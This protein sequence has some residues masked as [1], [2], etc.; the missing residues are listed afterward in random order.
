MTGHASDNWSYQEKELLRIFYACGTP[1]KEIEKAFEGKSIKAISKKG[2]RMLLRHG[3]G[4]EAN[5]MGEDWGA[6]GPKPVI[7]KPD[8]Y[9]D[10]APEKDD[11]CEYC[12]VLLKETFWVSFEEQ[13]GSSHFFCSAE[14]ATKSIGAFVN[15]G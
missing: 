1:L 9:T 5:G 4:W 3:E 10:T 13:S 6:Y 12:G 15:W 14:C 8:I 2:K 11:T 7:P